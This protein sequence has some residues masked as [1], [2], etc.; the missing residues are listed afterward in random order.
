MKKRVSLVISIFA[1]L[2]ILLAGCGA[3]QQTSQPA[4]NNTENTGREQAKVEQVLHLNMQG[5]PASVDPGI[6]ADLISSNLLLQLYEGLTRYSPDGTYVN[7]AAEK[8]ELSEDKKTYTFTLRDAKW[9][10]GDQVTAHDFEYAW[11][12]VLDPK[13]AAGNAY[14]LY[15]IKNATQFNSGKAT[16]DDVGVKALDD[17]TLQV[18][19]ENPTPYFLQATSLIPYM[20]INQKVDTE[21]AKWASEA[22]THVSNGPFKLETWEHKSKIVMAKNPNYWDQQAVR[23]E[24]VEFSMIEDENTEL[25][26][27]DNDELDWAGKPFSSLPTDAIPALKESGERKAIQIAGTYWYVFNTEKP[28]FNNPKIRKAF[29]YAIDRQL[30]VDNITQ[31]NEAP[32]LSAAPL[33][34]SNRT[35]GYFKDHDVDTAK[36]MLAA[37]LKELGLTE[38]PP[39]TL[40]FDTGDQH[41]KIAVAIQDQWKHVLGAE[42]RLE[43]KE[44]K[45]FFDDLAT[46]NFEVGRMGWFADFNDPAN[47]IE[48][49]KNK[50]NAI[51]FAKWE[52]A[53]FAKMMQ[54]SDLE[55]DPAKRMALLNQ[56]EAIMMDEMP[57]L[58]LYHYISLSMIKDKVKN[59]QFDMQGKADLKGVYLE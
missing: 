21:N 5:E 19:L 56:A 42:V 50:E 43:N 40:S 13:T 30:L 45:V 34:T 18:T 20:P 48:G 32:A 52:N 55:Q 37:G 57:I 15:Y 10:N 39:I 4:A 24:T 9:S 26:M 16:A 46:G 31:A 51:N 2:G 14:L 27:Y 36:T 59:V 8:V 11:K 53:D 17:K 38:L 12:R 35:E 7:A 58:P 1:I 3:S 6:G 22:S 29:A 23:L 28:P 54:Q 25:S 49:F 44:K 33:K 41:K 47:F